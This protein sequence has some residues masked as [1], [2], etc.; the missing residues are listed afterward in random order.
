MEVHSGAMG[1]R[2][3]VS[4]LVG[5]ALLV[6]A[7]TAPVAASDQVPWTAL[8]RPLH[9]PIL[10]PGARCPVS[11]VDR[12]VPWGRIRIFGASGIG[13]GP[14]Y[15]GLGATS[16]LLNVVKD[17]QYGS[18]WQGQ[19]V[20][21]YIAPSYRGRVLVRGR[22]LDGRGWLGFNG[23]RVPRDELRIEPYDTVSWSGQPRYSRGIPSGVRAL[24]S[25]CYGA[26]MD[27]TT[28][29]KVVVFQVDLTP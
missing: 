27:G 28:F 8:R 10:V 17:T 13:P 3:I 6:A 20:F 25:G 21:W 19:K 23:T 7:A 12:S 15:P 18:E 22:R 4:I 29:S 26:Q 9:L 1:R 14:V 16:G 24:T 2:L 5:A 11:N